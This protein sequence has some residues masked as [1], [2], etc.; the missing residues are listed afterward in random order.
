MAAYN[1]Q[2]HL[3]AAV[4]SILAQTF[5]DFE[6]I[7]VDDGSTDATADILLSYAQRDSRVKVLN[8]A[9]AG[10]A[11]ARNAGIAGSKAEFV[12]IMDSDD[13][14]HPHR[15]AMQRDFLLDNPDC[16]TV[17]CRCELIDGRDK[18]IKTQS[19]SIPLLAPGLPLAK[20][21]RRQMRINQRVNQTA[22]LRV[23]SLGRGALYRPWFRGVLEDFD[24]SLRIAEHHPTAHINDP[25]LYRYRQYPAQ[26]ANLMSKNPVMLWHYWCAA[27][28]S[29]YYRRSGDQDP[30]NETTPAAPGAFVAKLAS[31]PKPIR[32]ACIKNARHWCRRMLKQGTTAGVGQIIGELT[33]LATCRNDFAMLRKVVLGVM[34]YALCA[35]QWRLNARLAGD[36]L[37]SLRGKP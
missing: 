14:A 13:L 19:P 17:A 33:A 36:L 31:L 11:A 9:N 35:G 29:A 27:V 25:P 37:A 18:L 5:A 8:Q 15:L 28:L 7:V 24:L 26:A 2:A 10:P 20:L 6:L 4:E 30:I 16:A 1:A 3:A 21:L 34:F 32:D 12:A 22:M 23:K